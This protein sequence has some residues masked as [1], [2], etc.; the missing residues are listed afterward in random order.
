M[1]TTWY[2][3]EQGESKRV[4]QMYEVLHMLFEMN[5]VIVKDGIF[6]A[7]ETHFKTHYFLQ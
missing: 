3:F 2:L 1:N 5:K 4:M 7:K 6:D